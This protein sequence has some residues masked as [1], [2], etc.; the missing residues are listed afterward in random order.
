MKTLNEV[1]KALVH[2]TS[3]DFVRCQDCPGYSQPD[4]GIQDDALYCLKEYRD[5]KTCSA[6]KS[7]DVG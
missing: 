2:C 6:N 1:I 7:D 4:C 3:F 5:V